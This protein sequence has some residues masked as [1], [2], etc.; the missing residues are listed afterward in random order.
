MIVKIWG[1]TNNNGLFVYIT[2]EGKVIQSDF[3]LDDYNGI[4]NFFN[5]IKDEDKIKKKYIS[6]Y[7]CDADLALEQFAE[8]RKKDLSFIGNTTAEDKGFQAFHII[9][10]FP[11]NLDISDDE[12]HQ[13]G[14]ELCEKL[15]LYQAVVC[16]HLHPK[17]DENGVEHG[18]CKHNHIMFNAYCYNPEKQFGKG[19]KKI[20][21]HDCKESYAELQKYNDEIAIAHG[22]PII[23]NPDNEK[24]NSWKEREEIKK[25][26]SWKEN[27]RKDIENTRR[28][29]DNWNDFIDS[30]RASGYTCNETPNNIT[31]ITPDGKHRVRGKTLGEEY[32]KKGLQ[33]YWQLM[34]NAKETSKEKLDENRA[35]AEAD[36]QKIQELLSENS[37]KLFVKIIKSNEK[38]ARKND[39]FYIPLTKKSI[40]KPSLISYF[41]SQKTYKICNENHKTLAVISGKT[42]LMYYD[43]IFKSKP[44]R[45]ENYVV[46]GRYFYNPEWIDMRRKTAYKINLYDSVGRRRSLIEL[47]LLLA[48]NIISSET[49]NANSG[50]SVRTDYKLQGMLDAVKTA[51]AENISTETELNEKLKF[52]GASYRKVKS[53]IHKND[54]LYNQMSTLNNII[55]QYLSVKD[56][57]ENIADM[58]EGEEKA[59]LRTEHEKD[60]Q[61]YKSTKSVLY[62]YNL[63]TNSEIE[64]FVERYAECSRR[65]KQLNTEYTIYAEQYKRLKRLQYQVDKAKDEKYLYETK[66]VE[67]KHIR[68]SNDIENEKGQ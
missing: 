38:F 32:T 7:L 46:T 39:A 48:I 60:I 14:L 20:K 36:L 51:R 40:R 62:K 23:T 8:I 41:S 21:Y 2:E 42:L 22:L 15:G 57:C 30:M 52:S 44:K 6:G 33:I 53:K 61:L 34:K 19:T 16:S 9:Q 25:S 56:L 35:I 65:K 47:M 13:C 64:D 49:N 11:E 17:I 26:G 68:A 31:Y 28:V 37:Q 10:S 12:V 67:E 27:I 29:Y 1:I 18:K 24:K 4:E 66:S 55:I 43:E 58:H 59:T 63:T 5:Y 45:I 3:P 54:T 50:V